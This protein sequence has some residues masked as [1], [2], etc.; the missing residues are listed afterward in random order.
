MANLPLIGLIISDRASPI[1]ER[2]KE[3]TGLRGSI[4]GLNLRKIYPADMDELDLQLAS[5]NLSNDESLGGMT[6]FSMF[7]ELR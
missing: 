1:T 4:L 7:Y 3:S 5:V 6:C 2:A